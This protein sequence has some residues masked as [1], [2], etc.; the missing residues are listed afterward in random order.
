MSTTV[1]S[2]DSSNPYAYLNSSSTTTTDSTSSTIEDRF[3]K[4]LVTQLQNQDPLN[5]MDNSETTSQMAQISTVTG[6]EKLNTTMENLATSYA[7][8]QSYQAASLVGRG[9]M[10]S[11]DN[12]TLED[13]A[14]KGAVV[15]DG[16]ASSV[17]V[18]V[19]DS[20]G[21]TV[22]TVDL[23]AQSSGMVDFSWDGVN[24]DGTQLEDGDYTFSV[25]ATSG[26]TAVESTTLSYGKISS[27][28]FSSA[29]I[30]VNVAGV[31][32][33]SLSDIVQIL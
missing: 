3:L 18:T 4:L 21:N 9:V 13:G 5:P 11:G 20:Y 23:G 2:T 15:L 31:G 1:T 26:S 22:D 32:D 24:S 28:T 19:K 27:A 29:G 7:S 8:S 17:V 25:S 30:T 6:I 33:I 10:T 16:S 12:L 14:A